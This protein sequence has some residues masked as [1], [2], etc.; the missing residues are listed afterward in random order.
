MGLSDGN[1]ESLAAQRWSIPEP[2]GAAMSSA[3]EIAKAIPIETELARRG[4]T[5]TR[6]AKDLKGPCPVCGG[7]DRF[8]VTPS[9]ALWHCRGCQKGGSVIDLVLHLDKC[10][11]HDAV[12]TL[13]GKRHE[14]REDDLKATIARIQ[15]H[16]RK[17]QE[18]E[19]REKAADTA[20]ALRIW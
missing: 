5:L 7:R 16:K 14:R 8:V 12:E 2:A 4:Y 18:Q 3:V 13:A 17:Q 1:V 6:S 11:F 15:E 10:G 9:K 20:Y 19:T